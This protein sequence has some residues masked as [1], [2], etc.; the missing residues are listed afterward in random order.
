VKR[1]LPL[2][3]TAYAVTALS[4]AFGDA[5]LPIDRLRRIGKLEVLSGKMQIAHYGKDS[6][7]FGSSVSAA[8]LGEATYKIAVDFSKAT[9]TGGC[10][11]LPQ[12]NFWCQI[13][14]GKTRMYGDRPWT[15]GVITENDK[16]EFANKQMSY[17][18]A[19]AQRE[20]GAESEL[21]KQAQD[22]IERIARTYY[23]AWGAT[24]VAMRVTFKRDEK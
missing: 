8:Y 23:N 19:K 9:Y 3:V 4:S 24:N 6:F 5:L 21:M 22:Q 18:D 11:E 7:R 20:V 16:K 10:L 13:D 12:P 2:F 15:Q 1:I 17:I 14:E